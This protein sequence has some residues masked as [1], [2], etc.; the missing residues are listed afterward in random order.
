M[1]NNLIFKTL[2]IHVKQ[3]ILFLRLIKKIYVPPNGTSYMYGMPN[4]EG[5]W[6]K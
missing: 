6:E 1:E 5:E 3:I 2:I 4:L